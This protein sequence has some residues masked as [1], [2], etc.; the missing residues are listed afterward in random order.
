MATA[1][2]DSI[3]KMKFLPFKASSRN[4]KTKFTRKKSELQLEYG[5]FYPGEGHR[6]LYK[7]NTTENCCN[8]YTFGGARHGEDAGWLTASKIMCMRLIS[9]DDDIY[10][11]KLYEIKTAG[12][13][14]PALS[15][16][17][18]T[19]G[20]TENN[21]C[22]WGGL[23]LMTYQTVND[24]YYLTSKLR[25]NAE[26]M[27]VDMFLANNDFAFD[28][29]PDGDSASRVIKLQNNAPNP[30]AGHSFTKVPGFSKVIMFGGYQLKNRDL[31]SAS[32]SNPF[33]QFCEDENF[34]E[35]YLN[36]KSWRKM[37][38]TGNVPSPRCFHTSDFID[39]SNLAI[40][41]GIIYQ[42]SKAT[43]RLPIHD[44]ILS[45]TRIVWNASSQN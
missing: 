3:G 17:G 2:A 39:D 13:T 40:I 41:G 16:P 20:V 9:T 31:H 4:S 44:I 18:Y 33:A 29:L 14:L 23:D 8:L 10:A 22:I 1:T 21:M 24:I 19:F 26:T 45:L 28:F 32:F 12:S 11:D 37:N 42:N 43:E 34:Y 15:S 30:R 6:V 35:L 27:Q 7:Y 38:P 36:T 5:E 25:R